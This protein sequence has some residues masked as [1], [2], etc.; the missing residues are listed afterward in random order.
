MSSQPRSHRIKPWW[1]G[2]AYT[3]TF[4]SLQHRE[5]PTLT[6]TYRAGCLLL[7]EKQ[8]WALSSSLWARGEF[9]DSVPL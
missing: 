1:G 8:G 5:L 4:P 3:L 2:V 9:F 7:E 6:E